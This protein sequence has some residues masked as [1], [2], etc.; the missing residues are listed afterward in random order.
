MDLYR[1]FKTAKEQFG[2][3]LYFAD[4]SHVTPLGSALIIQQLVGI[5]RPGLWDARA[6]RA[7]QPQSRSGDLAQMLVVR[8]PT[9]SEIWGVFR[10][11]VEHGTSENEEIAPGV[12]RRKL[13]TV[14]PDS[15]LIADPTFVLHDSQFNTAMSMMRPYFADATLINWNDFDPEP[16]AREMASAQVI[17]IEVVE[18]DFYWRVEQQLGS[19]EFLRAVKIALAAG[20]PAG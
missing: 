19:P 9:R 13:T 16:V 20:P 15:V 14:G 1:V 12:A 17:L 6:L 5:L 10:P 2:R 4:D 3:Q 7:G 8:G 18:R 11:Q